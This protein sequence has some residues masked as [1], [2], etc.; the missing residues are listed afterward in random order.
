ML[1]QVAVDR[2]GYSGVPVLF[3]AEL[4]LEAGE[5]LCLLGHNGAGKTTLLKAVMGLL[6]VRQG[7]VRL[8]GEELTDLAPHEVPKRGLGYVP[9]GRRLW[10]DMSV[11]ENLEIGLM[12]RGGGRASRERALDLF[13]VLRER[14]RQ[15]AGT[16]SG[17]E[18]QMLALARALCLEPSV[19]LLDEPTEGLMPAAVQAMR[20]AVGLLKR[21]G[22]ATLLAESRAEAVTGAVDRVLFMEN[23]RTRETVPAA[24]LADE[25]GLVRRY[26]GGVGRLTPALG[27][28]AGSNC[29]SCRHKPLRL[30]PPLWGG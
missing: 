29:R 9:Q 6:P 13:P 7:S 19:L 20:D 12:A 8:N 17:G 24:S 14:L 30:P 5:V 28:G 2:G 15:R 18:Q 11:A 16:L 10:G 27:G 25:A 3:G 1:L 22:V 26:V 23:G 21:Q 4:S